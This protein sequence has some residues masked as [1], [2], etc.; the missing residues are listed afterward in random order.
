LL[1]CTRNVASGKTSVTV[2]SSSI[3]SSFAI[4]LQ[5]PR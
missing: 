2:P 5:L 4:N 3:A 1:T